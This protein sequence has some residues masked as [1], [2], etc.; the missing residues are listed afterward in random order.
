MHESSQWR[1]SCDHF[2]T[3]LD[4]YSET[5][6]RTLRRFVDTDDNSGAEM[7]WSSCITC[8]VYLATLCELIGRT[9]RTASPAMDALC[10]SNLEK[11]GRLTEETRLE[12]YTHLDLLL[13]VRT[14]KFPR[15]ASNDD[16]DGR[17]S[18]PGKNPWPC[19]NPGSTASRWRTACCCGIGREWSRRRMRLFKKGSPTINLRGY[20]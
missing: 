12:E 3:L 7:I 6:S 20:P 14:R 13:G 19:T 5:L 8:L 10:D 15:P 11:L 2:V 9:D 1:Q 17:T 18:S 4:E 16:T